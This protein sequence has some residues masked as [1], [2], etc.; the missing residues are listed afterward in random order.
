MKRKEPTTGHT[1]HG[2]TAK[3]QRKSQSSKAIASGRDE[4]ELKLNGVPCSHPGHVTTDVP[5]DILSPNILS[6]DILSPDVLSPG[7]PVSK[8][9]LE[10]TTQGDALDVFCS[11]V[12]RIIISFLDP[13]VSRSLLQT[14]KSLRQ[15][16][17]PSFTFLLPG[18]LPLNWSLYAGALSVVYFNH[19]DHVRV[20]ENPLILLQ[21]SENL[22]IDFPT[23]VSCSQKLTRV[24]RLWL[25]QPNISPELQLEFSFA[26]LGSLT[27]L[28]VDNSSRGR[29]VGVTCEALVL[30]LEHNPGLENLMVFGLNYINLSSS[31]DLWST[32]RLLPLKRIHLTV[33]DTHV[34]RHYSPAPFFEKIMPLLDFG[35]RLVAFSVFSQYRRLTQPTVKEIQEQRHSRNTSI[36]QSFLSRHT[37]LRELCLCYSDGDVVISGAIKQLRLPRHQGKLRF[38]DPTSLQ[39]LVIPYASILESEDLRRSEATLSHLNH[40]HTF[41]LT[42]SLADFQLFRWTGEIDTM[43]EHAILPTLRRNK[44]TLREIDFHDTYLKAKHWETICELVPRVTVLQLGCPLGES[45]FSIHRIPQTVEYLRITGQGIVGSIKDIH[46]RV[47]VIHAENA[48]KVRGVT[49]AKKCIKF[50]Q[51]VSRNTD[52]S[53]TFERDMKEFLLSSAKNSN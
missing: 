23:L 32:M 29:S 4:K 50:R 22:K 37:R 46:D 33:D 27:T 43:W 47:K 40:L 45:Q 20:N 39:A 9:I 36:L 41:G 30:L 34:Q 2:R 48:S 26:C 51:Q 14:T 28:V 11:D 10:A 52:A 42:L 25:C 3:E 7:A 12:W 31:E 24:T 15:L 16:A 6:P 5:E 44:S 21:R 35:D 1:T 38:E 53:L 49:L 8:D 19:H 18:S 17:L 13:L